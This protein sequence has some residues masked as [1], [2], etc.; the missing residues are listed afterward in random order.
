M[1][2]NPRKLRIDLCMIVFNF[3]EEW[4]KKYYIQEVKDTRRKEGKE[5]TERERVDKW[6][7]NSKCMQIYFAQKPLKW[8]TNTQ[9]LGCLPESLNVYKLLFEQQTEHFESDSADIFVSLSLYLPI[10]KIC[11]TAGSRL[12][13]RTTYLTYLLHGNMPTICFLIA[14]TCMC[15]P[16]FK[17]FHKS[18]F[19]HRQT[20]EGRG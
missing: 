4:L 3:H 11:F 17:W 5:T 16:S 19:P 2:I 14:I 18:C 12:C 9:N 13:S 10:T 15:D 7:Q 8:W 20:T 6:W 1:W